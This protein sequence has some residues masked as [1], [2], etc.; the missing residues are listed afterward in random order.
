MGGSHGGYLTAHLSAK[1]PDLFRGAILR[2]PVIDLPSKY[3]TVKVRSKFTVCLG[4]LVTSD[5]TDWTFGQLGLKYDQSLSRCPSAE[6]LILMRERSPSSYYKSVKCPS[7]VMLGAQDLRV[8]HSQGLYW[9]N[10]LKSVGVDVT[11]LI[12]PDANHGLETPE[13]EKNGF[14]A[15]AHFLSKTN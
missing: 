4:M 14:L 12:F 8:D 7:L 5:I 3:I 11:V 13:S 9:S 6:E 2:N 1:Y 10:L 15:I